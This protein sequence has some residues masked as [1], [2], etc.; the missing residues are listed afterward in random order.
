MAIYRTTPKT[1]LPQKHKGQ[2]RIVLEGFKTLGGKATLEELTTYAKDHNYEATFKGE[3]VKN[4]YGGVKGSVHWHLLQLLNHKEIERDG[5]PDKLVR[6]TPLD[7]G[8]AI[9][10]TESSTQ[11]DVP[12]SIM[13]TTFGLERDL[14]SAL[15][16]NIKQLDG[17]L[18]IVDGGK[19]HGVPSGKIDILAVASDGASV[20]IELKAGT[21]D[22]SA[23][24]QIL[25]Y[26]GDV[27]GAAK[28]KKVRG[29]LVAGDFTAKA[30]S[31]SKAVPTV[32]LKQYT[33]TFSFKNVP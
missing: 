8:A 27:I 9:D 7:K 6:Q 26:M 33:F 15:R 25:A 28:G 31:A 32:T 16:A 20:V 18:K 13:E 10:T 1:P 22:G 21:A 14:Q 5:A 17:S 3:W 19:E 29:I 23:I 11:A 12:D 4:N 2:R 24:S 30:I